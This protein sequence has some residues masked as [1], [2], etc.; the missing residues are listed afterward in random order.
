MS[1][2]TR[3]QRPIGAPPVGAPASRVRLLAVCADDFGLDAKVNEGALQLA[4]LGRLSAIS[5]MAGA[6]YWASGA[7]ALRTLDAAAVD[8]GLHLDLTQ[9]PF[10][11]RTRHPLAEWILRSHA[12]AFDR[13]VLRGEIEAQLD[14]FEDRMLRPPAFIDGHE[15]V[16]QLP[17]VR[18]VLLEALAARGLRPW[19]RSTRRPA[20][21][22]GL[23]PRLIEALGA[24]GLERQALAH[25]LGQNR[26]LLGVY[27]FDTKDR[28][29]LRNM[30]RWLALAQDG[31]LLMCHPAAPGCAGAPH[32]AARC[33]EHELLAGTDF[34]VLLARARVQVAPLRA[35][36][37]AHGHP[38]EESSL[39]SGFG[40]SLH[41]D[42]P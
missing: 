7:T 1:S 22:P 11:P 38:G 10:D 36:M 9:H 35:A 34:S 17:G 5:C 8:A 39:A 16:H 21:L 3:Q 23:K 28:V 24:A 40:A 29:Y 14:A 33:R 12:G 32:A 30:R 37:R 6:P 2:A 41:T 4:R 19:L 20:S 13:R 27:A 26:R 31:D 25:G 15:H 42:R 18:D